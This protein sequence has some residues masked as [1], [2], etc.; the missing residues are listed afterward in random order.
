MQD[1]TLKKL[2]KGLL[3]IDEIDKKATPKEYGQDISGSEV[4]KSMLRLIQGT[5][6]KISNPSDMWDENMVDFD[7]SNLIVI[8]MGAFDGLEEIKG[9]RLGKGIVGFT[10]AANESINLSKRFTKDDC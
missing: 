9:K 7:T 10:K 3:I 6:I 5:K 1:M 8:F 4:L 2:K